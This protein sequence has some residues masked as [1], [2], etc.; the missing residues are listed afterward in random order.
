VTDTPPFIDPTG[1][2]PL[3]PERIREALLKLTQALDQGAVPDEPTLRT[4]LAAVRVMSR[5][6]EVMGITPEMADFS[7]SLQAAVSAFKRLGR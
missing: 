7:V 2:G 5:A 1:R 4:A 6:H 3:H